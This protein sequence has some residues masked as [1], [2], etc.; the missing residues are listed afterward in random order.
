[1]RERAGTTR[2]RR[3]PLDDRMTASPQIRLP[4]C[5]QGRLVALHAAGPEHAVEL[6]DVV[7]GDR[8]R[9]TK[10]SHWVVDVHDVAGQRARLQQGQQR[11][12]QAAAFGY[13]IVERV[14]VGSGR[15][16]GGAG[17]SGVVADHRRCEIGYWI[18]GSHEGR[19]LVSDAVR[20]L[21]RAC[22]EA[23]IHRIELRCAAENERSAAVAHR[24]GYTLEGRLRNVRRIDS[25][26]ADD[27]LFAR[28]STDRE[29]SA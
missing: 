16:V 13:L 14:P 28:L 15:L 10:A 25:G 3:S 22:F 2:P 12:Q 7:D 27:L 5:L 21:S 29:P 17:V 8:Q 18:A 24:C 20:T 19:G 11:R 4:T 23:G 26:W 9:L 1:M 6:F